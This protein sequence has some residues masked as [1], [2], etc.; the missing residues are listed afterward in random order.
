MQISPSFIKAETYSII[1]TATGNIK[2][3]LLTCIKYIMNGLFY[4]VAQWSGWAY[5]MLHMNFTNCKF[6]IYMTYTRRIQYDNEL[7]TYCEI[8]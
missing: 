5:V 2:K 4:N 1:P 8:L 3:G 6:N 7:I